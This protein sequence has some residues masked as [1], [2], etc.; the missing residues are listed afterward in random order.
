MPAKKLVCAFYGIDPIMKTH[1]KK[2]LKGHKLVLSADP[3]DGKSPDAKTEVLGVFVESPVTKKTIESLPNLKL[4][5]ALSTGFDHIDVAAARK[6]N[7]PVCNVPTYGEN[8]VAEHAVALTLALTRKLFDAVK[9]V[10]E[11]VY[12][13][14]GLRGVDLKGKTVGVIGTGNIG[15]HYIQMMK[16]F[17]TNVIAYDAFPK[18]AIATEMGFT[19]V[20][21]YKLLAQSDIVSLHVPLFPETY[22][23][24]NKRNIKKMKKGSY[25]INT[26]R[27]G[28]VDPDALLWALNHDHLAGAALDVLEEEGVMKDPEQHVYSEGKDSALR[29]GAINALIIEHP[30]S[31]VTPHNAFNSIEAIHRILDTTVE[32][33]AAFASGK[34]QNDV[35][36]KKRK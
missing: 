25:L 27:G 5:V 3:L 13:Y 10:K 12:D 26:A 17:E 23:M 2:H 18:S 9:R 8:T 31:I 7:I 15:R 20:P 4:I 22:H 11:G 36:K 6:R 34:P 14:H 32:N 21:L 1:L 19:Y 24:I 30:K 29:T 16:C 28:L 35:T 33:I